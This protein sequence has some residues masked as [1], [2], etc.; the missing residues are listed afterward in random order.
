MSMIWRGIRHIYKKKNIIFIIKL[1][2]RL[3]K[4]LLENIGSKIQFYKIW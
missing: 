1:N 2:E 3:K 4:I